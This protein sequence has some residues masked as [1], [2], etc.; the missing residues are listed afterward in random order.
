VPEVDESDVSRRISSLE[1]R[2][3][4]LVTGLVLCAAVLFYDLAIRSSFVTRHLFTR[5]FNVPAPSEWSAV[6]VI[7]GLAPAVDGKSIA[8][9]LAG[10]PLSAARHQTRIELDSGGSQRIAMI[11]QMGRPRLQLATAPDGAPSITLFGS[12]GKP[13]WSAPALVSK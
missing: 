9:W 7:G 11:D 6:S 4:Y 2:V 13:M 3:R 8:F 10:S 1:R 5:E 12:D